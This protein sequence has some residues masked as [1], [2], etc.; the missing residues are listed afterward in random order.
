[1]DH[2]E[3]RRG[4]FL[5]RKRQRPVTLLDQPCSR[6]PVGPDD[7]GVEAVDDRIDF[8][9]DGVE[10]VAPDGDHAAGRATRRTSA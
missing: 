4:E 10:L 1:M 8:R 6:G 9:G 3:R 5:E 7:I 2:L